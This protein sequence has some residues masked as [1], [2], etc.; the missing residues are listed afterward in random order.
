MQLVFAED[1]NMLKRGMPAPSAY[2]AQRRWLQGARNSDRSTSASEVVMTSTIRRSIGDEPRRGLLKRLQ[3]I[4]RGTAE[5]MDAQRQQLDVDTQ[6]ELSNAEEME[7]SIAKEKM[8]PFDMRGTSAAQGANYADLK[9]LDGVD[10]LRTELSRLDLKKY[11]DR[12]IEHGYQSLEDLIN[13]TKESTADELETKFD[14]DA[15]HARKL[16]KG[17]RKPRHVGVAYQISF[18][19]DIDMK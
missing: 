8:Q 17:L 14:M 19:N 10:V 12:I 16:R 13:T 6:M 9:D 7:L 3:A 1:H 18:I 2:E 5:S 11:A 4:N 15:G